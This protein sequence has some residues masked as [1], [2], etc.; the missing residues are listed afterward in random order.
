MPN[1][2]C[3]TG[4]F[5]HRGRASSSKERFEQRAKERKKLPKRA[6]TTKGRKVSPAPLGSVDGDRAHRLVED[7]I[8]PFAIDLGTVH[9][10]IGVP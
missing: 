10:N 6:G 3:L 7:F 2:E 8:A 5:Q 1:V 9:R 4:V